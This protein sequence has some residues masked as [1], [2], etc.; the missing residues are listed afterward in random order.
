MEEYLH[1]NKSLVKLSG[2][3]TYPYKETTNLYFY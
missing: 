2:S 3:D 1:I